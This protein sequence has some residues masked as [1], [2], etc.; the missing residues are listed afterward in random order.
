MDDTIKYFLYEI[1][2]PSIIILCV[3][4]AGLNIMVF[5]SRGYCKMKSASLELTY[6]LALSDTWTS[7]VIGVS[8]FWNSYKPVVLQIPHQSFCFPLTLEVSWGFLGLSLKRMSP[9]GVLDPPRHL[10][11]E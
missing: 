3:F 11:K 8:L 5:I 1:C 2:I 9:C 6:S 7:I 10:S 4:A